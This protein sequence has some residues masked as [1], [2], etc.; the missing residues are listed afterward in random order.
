MRHSQRHWGEPKQYMPALPPNRP[1]I[2]LTAC[3]FVIP[4]LPNTCSHGILG[5]FL[6]FKYLLT[7]CLEAEGIFLFLVFYPCISGS[8][9]KGTSPKT[10][11]WNLKMPP[12]GKGKKHPQIP[13]IFRFPCWFSVFGGVLNCILLN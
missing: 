9:W 4:S 5:R 13:P 3:F 6:R 2:D 11:G 12:K 1:S 10:N 7:R 8:A